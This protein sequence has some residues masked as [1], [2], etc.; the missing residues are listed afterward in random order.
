MGA[1]LHFLKAL[2]NL[3]RQGFL[4]VHIFFEPL[5]CPAKAAFHG[6]DRTAANRSCFFL[7]QTLGS[8]Q[9]DGLTLLWDKAAQAFQYVFEFYVFFLRRPGFQMHGI[10]IVK[11]RCLMI[12]LISYVVIEAI[13]QDREQPRSQICPLLKFVEVREGFD[14]GVL[15]EVVGV[16]R[17]L[18]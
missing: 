14:K 17:T 1:A 5:P 11:W 4:A 15:D 12:F 2:L 10:H 16:L 18:G 13:A 6:T 7:R 8:Y 9:D 3:F